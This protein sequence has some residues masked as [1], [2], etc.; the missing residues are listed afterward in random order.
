MK[1]KNINVIVGKE[2]KRVF[3]DRKLI[4]SLFILPCLI[5]MGV[6]SLVGSLTGSMESD[7]VEHSANVVVVDANDELKSVMDQYGFN[8]LS[9]VEYIDGASFSGKEADYRND[10]LEAGIDLVVIQDASFNDKFVNYKGAGD[11]LPT[12]K[13]LYNSTENYSIEA[14]SKFQGYV[15]ENYRTQLM[16]ER[17]GDLTL[18]SVFEQQEELVVK[19]EKVN[20]QFIAM[21]LPY[22]I[23]LLLFSSA[24]S[25][26]IDAIAG[27][28]E[29][30]TLA[31][32]LLTPLTRT[33]IVV[34]K[35]ISMTILAGIS[36]LCYAGSMVLAMPLM[37]NLTGDSGDMGF[38]SISFTAL[39]IVELFVTMLVLTYLYIS[40]IAF[41][42]AI[43]KDTKSASTYVSPVYFVV[44][45]LAMMSMF[46]GSAKVPFERYFIPIYGNAIAISDICDFSLQ[47]SNFLAS[48]C[49]T[50]VLSIAL[51]IATAR[52]FKSE[53]I[54]FNA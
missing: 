17:F 35:L 23:V 40:I 47:T 41:L 26:G 45:A 8:A 31:S 28:K 2:L 30:G 32:M 12:I 4:F 42:A 15:L 46:N 27:E 14:Y 43:A 18:L 6:Y 36:S 38:G 33:E 3:G 52:V 37:S 24:M 19:E 48:L 11:A 7:I 25:V 22:M 5:M 39:Q 44:I 34:G 53:K 20:T 50:L 29:R 54:M 13:V 16:A 49:G 21:M 10:L 9:N 51:T 1:L